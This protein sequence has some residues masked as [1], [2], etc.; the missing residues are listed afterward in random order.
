MNLADEA[1]FL[2]MQGNEAEAC[3]LYSKS[4]TAE[5]EAAY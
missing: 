2:K 1:D 4:L 3:E 5:L